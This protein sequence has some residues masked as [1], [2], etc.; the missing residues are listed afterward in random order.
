[1]TA[2][3]RQPGQFVE[4][5]KTML[6]SFGD[7]LELAREQELPPIQNGVRLYYPED[8]KSCFQTAGQ[9]ARP[10][11]FLQALLDMVRIIYEPNPPGTLLL[12]SNWDFL[13]D[14]LPPVP[15]RIGYLSMVSQSDENISSFDSRVLSARMSEFGYS[16]H[17]AIATYFMVT[18][19]PGRRMLQTSSEVMRHYRSGF[20]VDEVLSSIAEFAS[21]DNNPKIRTGSVFSGVS[22][23]EALEARMRVSMWMILPQ[24]H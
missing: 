6:F 2:P 11:E 19:G 16:C 24:R 18:I 1:M 7:T 20:S 12:N 14:A 17:E 9:F 8:G 22:F 3:I 4:A 15:Y 5:M 23:D 10:R 21:G 13:I